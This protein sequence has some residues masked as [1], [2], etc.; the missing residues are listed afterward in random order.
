MTTIF[1]F[2][3]CV[4]MGDYQSC[5][6][7]DPPMIFQQLA[8]CQEFA[9]RFTGGKPPVDGRYIASVSEWFECRSKQ[10]STWEPTQ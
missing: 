5:H 9:S 3:I 6:M 1:A 10:V 4:H 2:F 8:T 7:T